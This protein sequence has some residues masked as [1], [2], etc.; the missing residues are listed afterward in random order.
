MISGFRGTRRGMMPVVSKNRVIRFHAYDEPRMNTTV[1]TQG[2]RARDV[3]L[4]KETNRQNTLYSY[5]APAGPS[6]VKGQ[7]SHESYDNQ[8]THRQNL[9]NFGF[10]N[11]QDQNR[12]PKLKIQYCSEIRREDSK[13]VSY[14]GQASSMVQKI[15]APLQDILR[16]TI[17][18]TNVHDS[19]PERNFVSVEKRM[20]V[21]DTNDTARPTIKETLIHDTHI[22]QLRQLKSSSRNQSRT[23][24]SHRT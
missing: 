7:Q 16:P 3:F 6:V 20:T 9:S 23:Y 2:A 8:T 15:V 18:E 10:R 17:K 4:D 19:S 24:E 14:L 1:V 11:A 13:D 5:A 12:E 21:H 22:G